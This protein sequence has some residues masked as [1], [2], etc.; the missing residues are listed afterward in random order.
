MS[1]CI[2]VGKIK[3]TVHPFTLMLLNN[4]QSHLHPSLVRLIIKTV[5]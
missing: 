4:L 3:M 5:V 2:F 1:N